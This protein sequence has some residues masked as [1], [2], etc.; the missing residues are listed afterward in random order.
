MSQVLCDQLG[1]LDA[2]VDFLLEFGEV[3]RQTGVVRRPVGHDLRHGGPIQPSMDAGEEEGGRHEERTVPDRV[4][5]L[6]E[7]E[8]P[9]NSGRRQQP[10]PR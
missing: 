6:R 1:T 10:V 2:L 9:G 7:G 8:S 3:V 5:E 4:G